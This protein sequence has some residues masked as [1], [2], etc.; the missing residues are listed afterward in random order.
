ML[1]EERHLRLKAGDPPLLSVLIMASAAELY[2]MAV[3]GCVWRL[4][5]SCTGSLLPLQATARGRGQAG[6]QGCQGCTEVVCKGASRKREQDMGDR[7]RHKRC[8]CIDECTAKVVW[9]LH[10]SLHSGN[11]HPRPSQHL[12]PPR[13]ALS[14]KNK[15]HLRMSYTCISPV[16]LSEIASLALSA[17]L[18][19]QYRTESQHRSAEW[20]LQQ[21]SPQ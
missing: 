20:L 13:H 17:P 18:C 1:G 14:T 5:S 6:E 16:P 2:R 10:S 8:T 19:T 21:C 11:V 12:T 3:T 15:I 9:R 7:Q 4:P